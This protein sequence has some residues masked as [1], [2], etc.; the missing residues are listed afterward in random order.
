M[1]R[2]WTDNLLQAAAALTYSTLLALVPL[3]V[4]TVAI[5]F[6]I[7]R[8]DAARQRM[9]E[10]F[11]RHAGARGRRPRSKAYLFEFTANAS[12]LTAIGRRG[13]AVT[14]ILLLWSI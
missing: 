11:F 9:T 12:N 10:I 5:L 6:G 14:A 3:L 2:F 8:F 7:S 13:L 1:A 4:L